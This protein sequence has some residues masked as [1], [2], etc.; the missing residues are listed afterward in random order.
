MEW[1]EQV[2]LQ[3]DD[4]T[5]LLEHE[6]HRCAMDAGTSSILTLTVWPFACVDF[7]GFETWKVIECLLSADGPFV[8][9]WFCVGR[10][11]KTKHF[12]PQIRTVLW[13]L[14]LKCNCVY[15]WC[16]GLMQSSSCVYRKHI[17]RL[18]CLVRSVVALCSS[19]PSRDHRVMNRLFVVD[20]FFFF[21]PWTTVYLH[22]MPCAVLCYIWHSSLLFD[23]FL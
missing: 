8:T 17:L 12:A 9:G 16:H 22:G 10:E 19:I 23:S 20:F 13:W 5:L 2:K 3:S 18:Q 7:P 14:L 4:G 11:E 15:K 6:R 1:T 21:L